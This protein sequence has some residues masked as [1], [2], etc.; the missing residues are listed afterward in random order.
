MKTKQI[1]DIKQ[2]MSDASIQYVDEDG[3][4]EIL[5]SEL[6]DD[7][8]QMAQVAQDIWAKACQMLDSILMGSDLKDI[9]YLNYLS[10]ENEIFQFVFTDSDGNNICQTIY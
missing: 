7:E 4:N 8:S 9:S 2:M 5:Y 6:S 3:F 10:L 1:D